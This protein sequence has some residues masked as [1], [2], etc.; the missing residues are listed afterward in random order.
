MQLRRA[1][2]R[3]DPGL[4]CEQPGERELGRRHLLLLRESVEQINQRLIRFTIL[5]VKAWD[6]AAEIR[7]IER[8]ICVNLSREKAFAQRAKWDEPDAEFFQGWQHFLFR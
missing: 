1:R 5:L 3:H 6:G 8:R 2:N 7:T 4:L